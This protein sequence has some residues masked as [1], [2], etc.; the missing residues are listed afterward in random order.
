[1]SEA[2]LFGGI[3]AVML[4]MLI[5]VYDYPQIAFL[6]AGSPSP[7]DADL[8]SRLRVEM[9]AGIAI[10]VAGAAAVL[11]RDPALRGGLFR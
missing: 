9:G 11:L 7:A 1:M 5:V 10:A 8:L 2:L 6:E 4:G 3:A